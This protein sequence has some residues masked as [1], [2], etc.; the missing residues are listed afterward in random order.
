MNPGRSINDSLRLH[1][2]LIK[3]LSYEVLRKGYSNLVQIRFTWIIYNIK[4]A[5]IVNID[6]IQISYV[7]CFFINCRSVR[8]VLWYTGVMVFFSQYIFKK[9][10]A[11][12]HH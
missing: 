3:S 2:H 6:S 5:S 11:P 12:Q 10:G 8:Q 7:K 4:N 1:T 9:Q